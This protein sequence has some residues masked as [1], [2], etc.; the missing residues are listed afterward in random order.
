MACIGYRETGVGTDL[1][2]QG[3][4]VYAAYAKGRWNPLSMT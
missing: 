3:T 4:C 2:Q 1:L